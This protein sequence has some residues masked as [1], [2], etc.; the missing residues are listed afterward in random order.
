VLLLKAG[1]EAAGLLA[2][3]LVEGRVLGALEDLLCVLVCLAMTYKGE[4]QL[5]P[6]AH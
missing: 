1:T 6:D 2:S 4:D 5:T 3:G